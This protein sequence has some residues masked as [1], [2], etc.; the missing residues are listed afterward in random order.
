MQEINSPSY[1]SKVSD[2]LSSLCSELSDGAAFYLMACFIILFQFFIDAGGDFISQYHV[3]LEVMLRLSCFVLVC[4]IFICMDFDTG[5][6]RLHLKIA[7]LV[8]LT[9]LIHCCSVAVYPVHTLIILSITVLPVLESQIKK[10]PEPTDATNK[11]YG[12]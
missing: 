3:L 1:Y 10:F 5:L 12:A 11:S 2:Q 8:W 4:I 6:T 9:S 7:L